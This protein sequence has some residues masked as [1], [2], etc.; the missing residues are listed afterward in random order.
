MKCKLT[1]IWRD[2]PGVTAHEYNFS[3]IVALYWHHQSNQDPGMDDR[4]QRL[5]RRHNVSFRKFMEPKKIIPYLVSKGVLDDEDVQKITNQPTVEDQVDKLLAALP[6]R[7]PSAFRYFVEALESVPT[8]AYLV[9]F[10]RED[11]E[12]KGSYNRCQ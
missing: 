2:L 8:Q 5:L 4:H 3:S 12:V 10:L 1:F 9:D 11:E 7:G 6:K